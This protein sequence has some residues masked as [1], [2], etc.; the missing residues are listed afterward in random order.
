MPRGTPFERFLS[1]AD[2]IEDREAAGQHV[3]Q[4]IP[5]GGGL[6]IFAHR[7]VRHVL[8][9]LH[10]QFGA[11]PPLL[12]NVAGV[13]PGGA[14]RFNTRARRPA[15][16]GREPVRSDPVIAVR[17]GARGRS[18]DGLNG[19]VPPSRCG[20]MA[21][22][23]PPGPARASGR[24]G[25]GRFRRNRTV[26]SSGADTSS[27]VSISALAKMTRGAKRRMLATTSRANTGS[28]SWERRPS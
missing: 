23:M 13:E 5:I 8:P 1:S 25:N 16:E 21:G 17:V 19:E 9:E 12:V 15:V 22:T 28:L 6:P 2:A 20:I 4:I 3:E 18:V 10:L 11:D 26:R 7:N 14:Q 24:C 27:V